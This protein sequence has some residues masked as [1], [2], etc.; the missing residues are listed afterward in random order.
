MAQVE[1][2]R[3]HVP[4]IDSLTQS[5]DRTVWRVPTFLRLVSII[6]FAIGM[7]DD[8]ALDRV[9]AYG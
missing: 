9:L 2:S 6:L 3:S 5:C 4:N 1:V 8:A 7:L